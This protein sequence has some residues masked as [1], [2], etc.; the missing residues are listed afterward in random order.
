MPD[1]YSSAASSS[2][3]FS[4]SSAASATASFSCSCSAPALAEPL[5]CRFSAAGFLAVSVEPLAAV[6][7]V[8][9]DPEG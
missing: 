2:L 9:E 4:S 7:L 3:A 1:S 8:V 6:P 5:T